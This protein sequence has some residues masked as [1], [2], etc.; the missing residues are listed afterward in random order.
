MEMIERNSQDERHH[1]ISLEGIWINYNSHE[2]KEQSK[3]Y[4]GGEAKTVSSAVTVMELFS[5]VYQRIIIFDD[6][7]YGNIV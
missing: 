7:E 1:F 6:L 5:I 3:Q 2:T 4:I